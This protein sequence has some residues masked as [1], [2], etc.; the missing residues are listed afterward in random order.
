MKKII[1]M[2]IMDT[3][4]EDGT[5]WVEY[6]VYGNLS[7]RQTDKFTDDD[8][9]KA[10]KEIDDAQNDVNQDRNLYAEIAYKPHISI[11]SPYLAEIIEEC[12]CSDNNMWYVDEG[13]MPDY[14][15][16]KELEKEIDKLGLWNYVSVDYDG[17][18]VVVFGGVVT[19]FR[20]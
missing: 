10:Q 19:K 6:D 8:I 13:E 11:C 5:V 3:D 4:Y 7:Y 16:K 12:R 20:F 15:D 9:E 18:D 17:Y 2:N 1:V 14:V